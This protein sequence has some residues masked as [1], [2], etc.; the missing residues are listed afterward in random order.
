MTNENEQIQKD[1]ELFKDPAPIVQD[2]M[3]TLKERAKQLGIT[4]HPSIGLEKLREKVTAAIEG[5]QEAEVVEDEETPKDD[6]VK[7]NL[8]DTVKATELPSGEVVYAPKETEMQKRIRV[9]KEA[10]RLIRVK[11][12]CMNPNKVNWP[13]EIISVGNNIVGD[14][15]KF[16]PFNTGEEGYHI[17]KIIYD[18]LVQRECPIYRQGAK[19]P[20]GVQ[21]RE[22]VMIREFS[23]EVLP[24][25]DETALKEL[26]QRQAMANGTQVG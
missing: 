20:N 8:P 11:I 4:H 21:K 25:L 9:R 3:T 23:I 7:A 19:G 24:D 6:S 14:Q 10:T 2:E 13:G 15:K 17:P 16:I 18:F 12:T 26:A 22:L 1:E 5:K